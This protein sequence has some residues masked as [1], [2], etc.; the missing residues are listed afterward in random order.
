MTVFLE[1]KS[2]VAPHSTT[3]WM[4][5]RHSAWLKLALCHSGIGGT[6]APKH[7]LHRFVKW[8]KYVRIQRQRRVLNQRLKVSLLPMI[9]SWQAPGLS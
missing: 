3:L 1:C 9:F 2:L 4:G 8:P 5:I 7:D 6:P